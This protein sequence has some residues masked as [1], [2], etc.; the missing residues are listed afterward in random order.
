MKFEE[1]KKNVEAWATE[2]G[3]YEHSTPKAQLLKTLSEIGELADAVI[4]NDRAGLIDAIGDVAVCLVNY[5]KMMNISL[6]ERDIELD[7]HA[8]TNISIGD[9]SY[10]IGVFLTLPK[11][12]TQYER[13]CVLAFDSL[14]S[15]CMDNSL[16]FLDCCKAAWNEIKDRKG[17]MVAG[18]AFVKENVNHD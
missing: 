13:G 17:R 1:F 6:L 18:G 2:R 11:S 9:I 8:D 10:I 16:D 3:I 4:K 15:I 12:M 5:A 14:G 7:I